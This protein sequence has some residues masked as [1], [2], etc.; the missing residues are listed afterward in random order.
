MP[1]VLVVDD[2]KTLRLV[3]Q[4][5]MEQEGYQTIEAQDGRNCLNLCQQQR[6]DII[7]LDAVMPEMDG[8]ECCR[9]LHEQFGDACPPILMITRLDDT[10]SV[11]RAFAVGADDY[12]TKPI[13]WAVLRQRVRRLMQTQWVMDELRHRVQEEE[14]LRTLLQKQM[15]Q[16]RCLSEQLEAAN[17]QLA[18]A[19]SQLQLLAHVDGL[20]QVAN[21]RSFDE[22]LQQEWQRALVQRAP[23]TL[24]LCDVDFFKAY[25]DT[26]GHQAG[27]EGLRTVAQCLQSCVRGAV[28]LVARYGGEEFAVVLPRTSQL[29]A[30]RVAERIRSEVQALAIAHEKSAVSPYLTLSLGLASAVPSPSLT[31]EALIEQAD[32]SLY[33]AKAQGRNCVVA[34]GG[35]LSEV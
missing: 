6:P 33:Q 23:L 5:A 27:D 12:V 22:Y 29:E 10:E 35:S 32:Q 25:N 8:F 24:I 15:Q 1:L 2:E 34:Y 18:D 14:A 19:N 16:E 21:R 7:L 3:L 20:T 30:Q 9:A 11:D 17:R 26:Y 31:L 4:R 28:D 13:H